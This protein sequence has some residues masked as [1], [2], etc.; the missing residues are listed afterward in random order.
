MIL[1]K[2][3]MGIGDRFGRQGKAQLQAFLDAAAQGIH[4]TPVWNKSHREHGITKT[5]PDSVRKEADNA[6]A[7]LNWPGAYFVDA[8]HINLGN[9]EGFIASSDF[10]TLDVADW[11]GKRANPADIDTFVHAHEQLAGTLPIPGLDETLVLQKSDIAAIAAKYLRAVQEA[12]RIYRHI[13][14]KKGAGTFVVELSMD[15]TDAPQSPAEL[16]LILAAATDEGIPVQTVA[17]KFI[18]RFNKGVEYVGDL[19][20]FTCEFEA[21]LCVI[22]YAIEAFG[23][24][25]N[26]KLSVHSGSDKFSLYGPIRQAIKKYNAGLHLKTAGTT[27]LEEL[28]GLASVGGEG[29]DI[30]REIYAEALGRFDELCAPYATVID[31]DQTRLPSA[32]TVSSWSSE[33]FVSALQHVPDCPQYNPHVRQLLH[34]GYKIAAEMG[35]RYIHALEEFET[36]IAPNVTRNIAERHLLPVFGGS[37]T[38]K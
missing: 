24:P 13:E 31:I 33:V 20:R 8:D 18:G 25:E 17:P 21:D 15:E 22:A 36:A 3:S 19:A 12:G 6:V 34:V 23:L 14:S 11:T 29:L 26:L 30:A 7:A 35:M 10:F 27:W 28:I 38:G 1:D 2:Y 16:L 37:T 9:V 5:T 4:V 32:G